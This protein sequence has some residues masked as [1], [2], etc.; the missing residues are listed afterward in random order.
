MTVR[1]VTDS[2]ADL[3][4]GMAEE[5][6]VVVV[7]LRVSFGDEVYRDGV[8]LT[9]DQFFAKL[10]A[11]SSLPTTSQPSAGDFLEVYQA[12][13]Q[14]ADGIVSIH[15]AASLSGTVQSALL[16]RQSLQAA[17]PIEIV[18]SRSV[19]LGLGLVVIKAAAAAR[20]GAPLADVVAVARRALQRLHIFF[21]VDTLEYLQR[22]GRIGRAQ[23]FL[24]TLLQVKPIL[25]LRDGEVHPLERTRTRARA[26]DRLFELISALPCVS[27][28][29][30]IHATT[31]DDAQALAQRLRAATPHAQLYMSRLGP[32]VGTHA[33]PG[34]VGVGALEGSD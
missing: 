30:V 3:P 7:P 24:G 26:L 27:D 20:A 5:L 12:L 21:M 28:Y 2:T 1:I 6:G 4:P 10:A 33:G 15:I 18:D 14:E 11:S 34:V 9:P 25:C 22:G 31:P 17:C 29:G 23:A 13:H 8:D 32:V 16:A 19:S